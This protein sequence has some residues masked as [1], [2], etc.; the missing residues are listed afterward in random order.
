MAELTIDPTEHQEGEFTPEEQDSLE[1]GERLAQEQE[2]LLAGKFKDAEELENAYIELQ[3]RFSRGERGDVE[4]DSTDD[5]PLEEELS[6]EEIIEE[7]E[8][9][10]GN[11]LDALWEN[12]IQ[13]QIPEDLAQQLHSLPQEE[14]VK[15]YLDQRIEAEKAKQVAPETVNQI[16][17][18][19]GGQQVYKEIIG[20]AANNLS[21]DQISMY[22]RVMDSGDPNAMWFAVQALNYAYRENVGYEGELLTGKPAQNTADVFRSQAEVVRAMRD[23]RYDSDPAYRMDVAEKLERSNLQF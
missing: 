21:E 7:S 19:V 23:P 17:E 6:E 10:D 1:V 22:D 15:M 5:Q 2:A 18:S 14:I 9:I 3:K 12:A 16:Q 20:W 8:P 11:L 13:G 4:D